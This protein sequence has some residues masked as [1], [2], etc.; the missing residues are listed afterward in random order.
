[1]EKLLKDSFE[2]GSMI[3]KENIKKETELWVSRE[4]IWDERNKKDKFSKGALCA[5]NRMLE[6]IIN[7]TNNE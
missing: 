1:M 6:F 3:A 4:N 5:R 7:L 2:N